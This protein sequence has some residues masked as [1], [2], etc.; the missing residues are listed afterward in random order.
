ML[1]AEKEK[2]QSS[3]SE[4]I[5]KKR[6]LVKHRQLALRKEDITLTALQPLITPTVQRDITIRVVVLA[7]QFKKK[8]WLV[9]HRQLDTRLSPST[10]KRRHQINNA[11]ENVTADPEIGPV[12]DN[13]SEN[14]IADPEP[15]DSIKSNSWPLSSHDA[16]SKTASSSAQKSLTFDHVSQAQADN[17]ALRAHFKQKV[18]QISEQLRVEQTNREENLAEY[19]ELA[20]KVDQHQAAQAWLAFE[21]RNQRASCA[22]GQLHRRLQNCQ[23]RLQEL[24]HSRH[25]GNQAVTQE[26]QVLLQSHQPTSGKTLSLSP[27]AIMTADIHLQSTEYRDS[28]TNL[29]ESH[30]R[31]DPSPTGIF[32]TTDTPE[33]EYLSSSAMMDEV[34]EIKSSK[35]NLEREQQIMEQRYLADHRLIQNLLKEEQYRHQQ[36]KLKVNDLLDLHET[37]TVNL[38]Q[39]LND[40]EEKM[41]YQSNE[42]TREILEILDSFQARIDKLEQQQSTSQEAPERLSA[43]MLHSKMINLLFAVLTVL[44]VCI[45]TVCACILPLVKTRTRTATTLAALVLWAVLWYYWDNVLLV[46]WDFWLLQLDSLD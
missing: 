28:I 12:T 26:M 46:L 21:R 45:S 6:W 42:Q 4:R 17:R 15:V 41:V 38:K 23:C 32:S 35:C 24:E 14:V 44:V 2:I 22:I 36:L 39:E 34:A 7:V 11:S 1:T 3:K 30:S 10:V 18:L 8:R 9:K 29:P 31:E 19:L 5:K 20:S 16:P 43:Q 27:S 13:V 40:R 25:L 37:E 33:W